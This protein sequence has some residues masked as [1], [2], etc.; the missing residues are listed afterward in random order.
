MGRLKGIVFD[1]DDTLVNSTAAMHAAITATLPLLPGTTPL[2]LASALKQ[3]YQ[4]LWGYPSDGYQQLKTLPPEELRHALTVEAL[5]LLGFS[6]QSLIAAVRERYQTTEDSLLQ[7]LPGAIALLTAL[8]EDFRLGIITNG[9]SLFQRAKLTQVGLDSFFE[10]VVADVDFGAPKPDPALF[11][12]TAGLLGLEKSELL[13]AGD[14]VEADI[15]GANAAGWCSVY[16]GSAACEEATYSLR[17][18][19]EILTLEP[20][21]EVQMRKR[22]ASEPKVADTRVTSAG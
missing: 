14:S 6:D 16:V 7:P 5:G 4:N 8:K 13:F 20:V 1:L 3:G 19:E 17:A 11:A 9:P 21:R 15:A 12:Y 18:L 10:V 22:L 2:A